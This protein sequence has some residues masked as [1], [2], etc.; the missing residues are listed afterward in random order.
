MNKDYQVKVKICGIT[1]ADTALAAVE[2][3]AD[4]LGFVFAPSRRRI[5][6]EAARAIIAQLPPFV[7][8][9]GVFVNSSPA[10]IEQIARYCGLTAV[11]LSG[12]EPPGYSLNL[13]LPVIRSLRVGNGKPVPGLNGFRADAFLF[14]T[15][16]EKSYGG[17]GKTFDWSLLENMACPKPLLLAGG[18]NP[19]NVREAVRTVRPYAVDVSGGVE[20]DGQKDTQKIKEFIALAKGV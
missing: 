14:D 6:P 10:E 12:D 1:G 7:A 13:S 17:T 11:Q 5:Q 2:A 9:V 16:C 20:T 19:F 8:R 4:A 15:Y 3:G 18:L